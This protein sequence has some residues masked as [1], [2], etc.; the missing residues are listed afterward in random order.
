[1]SEGEQNITLEVEERT[2]AKYI[3]DTYVKRK[4]DDIT[5]K[6]IKVKESSIVVRWDDETQKKY[7]KSSGIDNIIDILNKE[8]AA[9]KAEEAAKKAEEEATRVAAEEATRVAAEEAT[10]AAEEAKKESEEEA[11]QQGELSRLTAATNALWQQGKLKNWE[12]M[13]HTEEGVK[14]YNMLQKTQMHQGFMTSMTRSSQHNITPRLQQQSNPQKTS[15]QS[16]P[17]LGSMFGRRR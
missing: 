10:R 4:E 13:S 1:M 8:E 16:R 7:L 6:I 12:N 15:V 9:K 14:R 17:Q 2:I 5:G 11:E 3:V